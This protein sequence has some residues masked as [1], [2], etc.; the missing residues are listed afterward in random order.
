MRTISESDDTLE[1]LVSVTLERTVKRMGQWEYENWHIAHV[2]D[3]SAAA[4]SGEPVASGA[5][6]SPSRFIWSPLPIILHKDA[7]EGYWY[8]LSGDVPS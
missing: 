4:V 6:L 5:A 2:Q 1:R 7:T 3:L 8:N